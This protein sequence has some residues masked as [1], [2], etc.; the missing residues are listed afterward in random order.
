MQHTT[1]DTDGSAK[2]FFIRLLSIIALYLFASSFISILYDGINAY[3]PDAWDRYSSSLA[4]LRWELACAIVTFPVYLY[5]MCWLNRECKQ[6]PEKLELKSRKWFISFTLFVAALI[7]M[8][9]LG[10]L[11]YHFLGN[12]LTARFL[13]KVLVLF[14]V[15]GTIFYYYLYDLKQGWTA[16]QERNLFW[17]VLIIVVL[18]L[19]YSVY[20]VEKPIFL[21][22]SHSIPYCATNTL[23]TTPE[24][25]KIIQQTV[26]RFAAQQG[27]N[28]GNN[29][30]IKWNDRGATKFSIPWSSTCSAFG[31]GDN[32]NGSTFQCD[33]SSNNKS[34]CCWPL[35]FTYQK[36]C[37]TP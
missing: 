17:S 25:D 33:Y 31:I 22:S 23:S 36:M 21:A 30:L 1:P 32:G 27:C 20:K 4:S 14:L 8:S 28:I 10:A 16:K 12:Q 18:V 26:K 2:D 29:C 35:G 11:I 6:H 13:L 5:T 7:M 37:T 34:V 19:G 24:E 9:D 15:T 3:F